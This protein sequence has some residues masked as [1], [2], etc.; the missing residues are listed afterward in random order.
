MNTPKT[1]QAN[2]DQRRPR[3]G[4]LYLQGFATY[5][6][7]R[8]L[9]V[10]YAVIRLLT[11]PFRYVQAQLE[12]Q[13]FRFKPWL[14][15][16]KRRLIWS[17]LALVFLSLVVGGGITLYLWREELLALALRLQ[18][19]LSGLAAHLHR[20]AEPVVVVATQAVE[21]MPVPV[22]PGVDGAGQ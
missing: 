11:A 17:I 8:L 18:R 9:D 13:W 5:L 10:G 12:K 4:L 19:Y 20:R 6:S 22:M 1:Q 14:I 7:Y 21:E 3:V 15:R 16:H 2:N